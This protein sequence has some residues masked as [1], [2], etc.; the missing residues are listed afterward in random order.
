MTLP[1]ALYLLLQVPISPVP[2][3]ERVI[4][5][6]HSVT[7]LGPELG[8]TLDLEPARLLEPE[9]GLALD[10]GN[11]QALACLGAILPKTPLNLDL[12]TTSQLALMLLVRFAVLSLDFR[13]GSGLITLGQL[14]QVF[15]AGRMVISLDSPPG[16]AL[17]MFK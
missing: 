14:E 7:I 12:T 8:L 4:P 17:A 16:L 15:L 13:P 6:Y 11:Q 5:A 10:T 1:L 2:V 9:P 3:L